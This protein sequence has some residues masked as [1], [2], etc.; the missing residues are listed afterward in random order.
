MRK[1]LY[2]Y[3]ENEGPN[4]HAHVLGLSLAFV[5]R[6]QNQHI[7][8]N[9]SKNRKSPD[10]TVRTCSLI[11]DFTGRIWHLMGLFLGSAL[12]Y[13]NNL[14]PCLQRNDNNKVSQVRTIH[15]SMAEKKRTLSINLT[16]LCLWTLYSPN[17]SIVYR[18]RL[19]PV[20]QDKRGTSSPTHRN[21]GLELSRVQ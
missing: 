12:Y 2:R 21:N 16:V 1:G 10:Q 5:A 20:C 3:Q 14:K 6:L 4:Q 8:Y 13:E 19:W 11:W 7:L 15:D 17:S 9:M 18:R